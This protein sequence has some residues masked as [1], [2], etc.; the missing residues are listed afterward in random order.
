MSV[1]N[2]VNHHTFIL[3]V[4]CYRTVIEIISLYDVSLNVTI[5]IFNEFEEVS[6]EPTSTVNLLQYI[7]Q[8]WPDDVDNNTF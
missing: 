3:I 4:I 1:L 8:R 5:D 6:H 2:N 7:I